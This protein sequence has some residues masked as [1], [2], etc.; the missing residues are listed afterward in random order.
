MPEVCCQIVLQK[1]CG[2]VDAV[3]RTVRRSFIGLGVLLLFVASQQKYFWLF[4]EWRVFRDTN[5]L[6]VTHSMD[7]WYVSLAW[8][9]ACF[10]S[11][12]LTGCRGVRLPLAVYGL[13]V[14]SSPLWVIQ[15][16]SLPVL[17]AFPH[18]QYGWGGLEALTA[19]QTSDLSWWQHAPWSW[20]VRLDPVGPLIVLAGLG[21]LVLGILGGVTTLSSVRE[22]PKGSCLKCG[23]D[24][25][26]N[27]SGVCPEC[28]DCVIGGRR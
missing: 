24:L 12:W 19:V 17:P 4:D 7:C 16:V 15:S 20:R 26:G 18:P 28:G 21:Q 2:S 6:I 14:L 8:S 22:V 13:L 9:A 5:L 10:V 11:A 27:I 3:L 25:T 1:G 23:Y